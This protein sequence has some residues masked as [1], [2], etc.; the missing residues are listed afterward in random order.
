MKTVFNSERR[1]RSAGRVASSE[2][3]IVTVG[4]RSELGQ[5][6]SGTYSR[7]IATIHELGSPGVIWVPG[8][9][10]GTLTFSRLVGTAGFFS[11]WTGSACGV[12]NP[13]SVDLG[14]GECVAIAS[15]GLRFSDA[16]IESFNFAMQAGNV[17][18]TEGVSMRIGGMSRG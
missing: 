13:V 2:Y 12:L 16:M 10:S 4:G 9:E 1:T 8:F 18:I 3:A 7:N 17:E 5:N 14:A 11:G 6:I 15:G